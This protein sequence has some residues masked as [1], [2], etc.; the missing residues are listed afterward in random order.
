M[1]RVIVANWR[2][3][4]VHHNNECSLCEQYA[5]HAVVVSEKPTAEIPSHWIK[6]AF[7][8]V[9]PCMVARIEGNAMDEAH[10]KLSWYRDRYQD[11][12]KNSKS[13]QEQLDYKKERCCKV[14]SELYHLQKED[15]NKGKQREGSA[16]H[17]WR[18]WESATDFDI[19]EQTL[20]KT[21]RKRQCH[22]TGMLDVPP[23]GMVEFPNTEPMEVGPHMMLPS[24]GSGHQA[25]ETMVP[26]TTIMSPSTLAPSL[27]GKGDPPASITRKWPHPLGKTKTG[28]WPWRQVCNVNAVKFQNTLQIARA[29]KGTEWTLEQ[30]VIIN[31]MNKHEKPLVRANTTPPFVIPTGITKELADMM[32]VWTLNGSICPLA[33]RQLPDCTLHLYNVGFYIW[34]RKISPK[35]DNK[36][37]KLQFW[38]LFIL[39]NW[40]KILMNDSFNQKGSINGCMWLNTHKKCLPLELDLK[41]SSLAQWLGDNA[42]LT[43]KL[44]E[45][46]VKPYAVQCAEHLLLG[47][48]WN[49]AAKRTAQK[50]KPCAITTGKMVV[51]HPEQLLSLLQQV[52]ENKSLKQ[53]DDMVIN[54]PN[55]AVACPS[56]CP[57]TIPDNMAVLPYE[58]ELEL[59]T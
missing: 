49:E 26:T 44:V 5:E 52:T 21:S 31:C 54:E 45:E 43:T 51:P 30:H 37:F 3:P 33:V 32:Q 57:N 23:R 17:K 15:K 22:D 29:T 25:P 7:Q 42:G 11:T 20:S 10:S 9:W 4:R 28:L 55:H 34:L 39:N 24:V 13:L 16:T 56:T 53:N 35:E 19:A 6:L 58:D 46:I 27:W 12:I 1:T 47:T 40:F 36:T 48:T 59:S 50:R 18:E 38:K 14:E 2:H 8:T 41:R